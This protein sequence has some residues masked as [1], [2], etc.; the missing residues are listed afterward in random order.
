ML[1]IATNYFGLKEDE[2][3]KVV[4]DDGI[5]FLEK[6]V[7]AGISNIFWIF[8]N[9]NIKRNY[10]FLAGKSYKAILFDVDNKDPSVG[11]SFPSKEFLSQHVM[12]MVKTCIKDNG[13]YFTVNICV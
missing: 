12:E 13:N 6:A 9:P 3:L 10:F 8:L 7:K 5:E 4:I 11:M 2:R 1:T